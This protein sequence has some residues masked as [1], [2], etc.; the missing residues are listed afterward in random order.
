MTTRDAKSLTPRGSGRGFWRDS[1]RYGLPAEEGAGAEAAP[2]L[3]EAE[4]PH[5]TATVKMSSFVPLAPF[6]VTRRRM[7]VQSGCATPSDPTARP[8]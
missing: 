6:T 1:E 7:S 8:L 4:R 2:S 5:G 3:L